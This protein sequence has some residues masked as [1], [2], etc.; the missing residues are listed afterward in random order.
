MAPSWHQQTVVKRF[1]TG[2]IGLAV[3]GAGILAVVR[4][5]FDHETPPEVSAGTRSSEARDSLCTA[6]ALIRDKDP[7][8]ARVIFFGRTHDRLHKLAAETA[9]RSRAAAARLLEAKAKVEGG[10]DPPAPTLAEDLEAVAA[11]AGQA[12]AVVGGTDPGPC[13]RVVDNGDMTDSTNGR[14]G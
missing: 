7:M 11:A 14:P 12:M 1:L 13:E 2:I 6:A 3:I 10:F 9:Q 4:F 5:A 8:T